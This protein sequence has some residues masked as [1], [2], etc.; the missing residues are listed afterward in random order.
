MNIGFIGGGNIA[1]AIISGLR[2]AESFDEIRVVE[3][4]NL[5]RLT[6]LEERYGILP[7]DYPALIQDSEVI[8]L[9]IKPKDIQELLE[10]IRSF[11][12]QGK[13]FISVVAGIPLPVVEKYLP[14]AAVVRVMPNTACAV[15][16]AISGMVRGAQVSD[17][18][19][20]AATR[21]FQTVGQTV[22]TT[23]EK[24]NAVT[25]ISGSGP[26]YYYLFTEYLI[27]AGV[28]LGLNASE[29]EALAK[30]TAFGAAQMMLTS[31]KPV[32]QLRAEVTSPNGT[33]YEAIRVFDEQKLKQIIS[34]AVEACANRGEEM[35]QEYIK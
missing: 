5:E 20:A 21:I 24:M 14:G 33:T 3:K 30:Q 15:R 26:A 16:Q 23:E 11:P 6:Y 12:V 13:L 8:L 28:Q 19:A 25:A 2:A 32:T 18:Q 1:E 29:A 22:W 35:L 34:Q 27:Q 31:E 17:N 9:T 7:A 10:Y 4:F